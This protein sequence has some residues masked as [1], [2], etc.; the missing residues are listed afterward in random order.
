MNKKKANIIINLVNSKTIINNCSIAMLPV[1][2]KYK[3][4]DFMINNIKETCINKILFLCEFEGMDMYEY[5]GNRNI[6]LN[7][8]SISL[9]NDI[10]LIRRTNS[11]LLTQKYYEE[12]IAFLN[13]NKSKYSVFENIDNINEVDINSLLIEHDLQNKNI[14]NICKDN[15]SIGIYIFETDFL[16]DKL[17]EAKNNGIILSIEDIIK[18]DITEHDANIINY[19][20]TYIKILNTKN[21]FDINMSFLNPRNNLFSK[22][23]KITILS[24]KNNPSL[25]GEQAT[26]KNSIVDRG[27]VINGKVENCIIS[28]NVVI[29]EKTFI[30]N[31][32]IFEN[33]QIGSGCQLENL[34]IDSNLMIYDNFC[35][36]LK[37]PIFFCK[38]S[39]YER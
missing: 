6:S 17:N 36:L 13:K 15:K 12:K 2:A 11:N 20:G 26:I 34:I 23:S 31:C 27:C 10:E 28:K 35:K 38:A 1:L 8:V 24:E 14:S 7:C 16:I 19:E 29:K 3:I 39:L 9:L 37:R 5:L 22:L 25:I 4:L 21:Y 32:I 30:K 18:K 33:S